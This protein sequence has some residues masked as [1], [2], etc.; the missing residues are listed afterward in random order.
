MA[1][2]NISNVPDVCS[3]SLLEH[4]RFKIF[5]VE[6]LQTNPLRTFPRDAYGV[7]VAH[8]AT[9]PP[10][11]KILDPP[12]M[13]TLSRAWLYNSNTWPMETYALLWL[14]YT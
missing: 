2:E 13:Y 8:L 12:L 6:T 3:E 9:W 1:L 14:Y 11:A 5:L 4:F 10:W 7:F